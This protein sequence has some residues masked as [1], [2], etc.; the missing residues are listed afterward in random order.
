MCGGEDQQLAFGHVK[1][2]M[3]HRH[4]S[5]AIYSQLDIQ[6]LWFQGEVWDG[7]LTMGVVNIKTAFT[8]QRVNVVSKEG[9]V[10]RKGKTLKN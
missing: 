5:R 2:R 8:A 10:D 9:S 1:F 4:P 6:S 7:V 3:P